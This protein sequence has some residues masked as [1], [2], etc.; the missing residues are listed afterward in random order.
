M[1]A[2]EAG[3]RGGATANEGFGQLKFLADDD[4]S[5][6]RCTL[7]QFDQRGKPFAGKLQLAACA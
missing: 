4:L 5:A 7:I 1:F 3:R 2:S 6:R